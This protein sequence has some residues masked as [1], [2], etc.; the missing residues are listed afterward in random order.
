MTP[1]EGRRKQER[2]KSHPLTTTDYAG[3]RKFYW[4][5][6]PVKTDNRRAIRRALSGEDRDSQEMKN[7]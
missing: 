6:G 2:R 7:D 5:G 4:P 1:S 3:T